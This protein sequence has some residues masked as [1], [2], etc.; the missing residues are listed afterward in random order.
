MNDAKA[1]IA[2]RLRV[3]CPLKCLGLVVVGRGF[4]GVIKSVTEYSRKLK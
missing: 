4:E 3:C 1:S 2:L